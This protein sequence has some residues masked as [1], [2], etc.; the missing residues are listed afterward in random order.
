MGSYCLFYTEFKSLDSE[1]KSRRGAGPFAGHSQLLGCASVLRSLP[2]AA[3]PASPVAPA[4]APARGMLGRVLYATAFFLIS[5]YTMDSQP[6]DKVEGLGDD[7]VRG[8]QDK[9]PIKQKRNS[10][11]RIV[12]S[13]ST[14]TVTV[15]EGNEQY[16]AP[17]TDESPGGTVT[18]SKGTAQGRCKGSGRLRAPRLMRS[19]STTPGTEKAS[20]VW[21]SGHVHQDDSGGGEDTGAVD[22]AEV[23][24]DVDR[25]DPAGDY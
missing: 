16:I 19:A 21:P 6:T 25:N 18:T 14:P 1:I 20:S 15:I 12:V 7:F 10:W 24:I 5:I 9:T 3:T 22:Y 4:L 8:G 23:E 17:W 2:P 13:A 11:Q